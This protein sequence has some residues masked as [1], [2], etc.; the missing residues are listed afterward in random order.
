MLRISV[1]DLDSYLYWES[2]EDMDFESLLKRLRG[3]EP[4]SPQMAAGKAFHRLLEEAVPGEI[5]SATVDGHQFVFALDGEI[6]LP[7]VRELKG[8]C[9]FQTGVGPVTLVGKVDS[10]QG[11]EVHD[12]KLT[13]RFDAERYADSYQWR[14][15]LPI[16]RAQDF[17]Y[18]VF[19]GRYEDEQKVVIYDYHRLRFTAYPGM[20]QDVQ[21]KLEGLA[22]IV[23]KYVPQKIMAEVA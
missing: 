6:A 11:L 5:P 4:P 15:Y 2:A 12:Y 8:E 1:T 20:C 10:L 23:A 13:E 21:R 9:V 14:C 7:V 3:E 18:D 22:A 17:V 16:F 19:Q